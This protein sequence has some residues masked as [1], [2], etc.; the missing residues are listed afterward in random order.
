MSTPEAAARLL[1]ARTRAELWSATRPW[2]LAGERI[3]LVPTMGNLHT[4][5]L[6]LVTAAQ[7]HADR[8]VCSIYVNPTQFGAGED[9]EKYPR[10]VA[11]D[12]YGLAGVGCDLA[13][14]PDDTTMYPGSLADSARVIAPP[15]LAGVLEGAFRPGH[16][17][18]VVTVVARLFNLCRPD[19][20]VFGEKDYQQL[21]IVRRLVEDLGY[22]LEIVPVPTVREAGALALSSRNRYLDEEGRR[23]AVLLSEVLR[24]TAA[25]V[26]A[27]EAPHAELEEAARDRLEKGGFRVDYVAVRRCTDLARGR[28]GESGLRVLAAAWLG[29]TRL[30]DNWP[31]A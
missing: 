9:F 16:F 5:H 24:D 18:G 27:D 21:L 25:R 8:V 28:R 1:Q 13:F 30:I 29:E 23:T 17:D 14:L 11:A 31:A 7:Q 2:R 20:A 26:A 3:A 19:V 15:S 12:L 4:G 6:A 10:T 22:P